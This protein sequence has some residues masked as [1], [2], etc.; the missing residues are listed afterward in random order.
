[1][2]DLPSNKGKTNFRNCLGIA[3]VLEVILL[4]VLLFVV[5]NSGQTKDAY[6]KSFFRED[7]LPASSSEVEEENVGGIESLVSLHGEETRKT[8]YFAL[9]KGSYALKVEYTCHEPDNYVVVMSDSLNDQNVFQDRWVK[10]NPNGTTEVIGFTLTSRVE[11]L[12][13]G[14]ISKTD[15]AYT[16]N[17]LTVSTID[18]TAS[19]R[20]RMAATVILWLFV[21]MLCNAL[22]YFCIKQPER[23]KHYL[24]LFAAGLLM[25]LPLLMPSDYL[26]TTNDLEF[27][28]M[29]IYGIKDGILRGL[30]WIKFQTNWYNGYGYMVSAF[31]GDMLLYLPALGN[32]AGLGMGLSYRLF[33]VFIN[34]LTLFSAYYCFSGIF[35]RKAGVSCAIT[36]SFLIYR[37]VDMF[38]R[39]AVGEY[40]AIAFLPFLAYAVYALFK[41]E[42]FRSVILFVIGFTGTL[43]SHILTTEMAIPML[44]LVF[45]FHIRQALVPKRLLALL[46]AAVSVV[47]TNLGFIVPFLDEAMHEKVKVMDAARNTFSLNERG[48]R[49]NTVLIDH[50]GAI[51]AIVLL[52]FALFY[53]L[54][55]IKETK[56]NGKSAFRGEHAQLIKYI[57]LTL[58]SLVLCSSYFPWDA[59]SRIPGMENIIT[60]IQFPWRFLAFAGLFAILALGEILKESKETA[61]NDFKKFA[62]ISAIVIFALAGTAYGCLHYAKTEKVNYDSELNLRPAWCSEH[63]YVLSGTEVFDTPSDY[64]VSDGI[65]ISGYSK[66]G[67]HIHFTYSSDQ[68]GTILLPLF[69]YDHYRAT[70]KN[71]T[72][73]LDLG[74]ESGQNNRIQLSLPSSSGEVDVRFE[75]PMSWTL[76]FVISQVYVVALI[77]YAVYAKKKSVSH[78]MDR[79]RDTATT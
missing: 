70:L 37:F 48:I 74:T 12:Y 28:V 71:N 78:T 30:P 17:S 55:C 18:A 9:E 62:G 56:N 4:V 33:A 45:L 49:L 50:P 38:E 34:L 42:Y 8:K 40:C 13:I 47:I 77:G 3:L 76:S 36:Y 75:Y 61:K 10:P 53:L 59:L 41:D 63:E 25:S 15:S 44:I 60:S 2:T 73:T 1:M 5:G 72:T 65:Q 67:D 35:G 64:T 39:G 79:S 22:L 29:R 66:D 69:N 11:D 31:Y 24:L 46:V 14:F 68:D 52:F 23:R 16:I 58:I 7:V 51:P 20:S 6:M 27:H 57:L 26:Y 21:C 43:N 19:T 32:I 54:Y